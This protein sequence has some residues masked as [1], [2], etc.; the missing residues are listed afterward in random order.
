MKLIVIIIVIGL[1]GFFGWLFFSSASDDQIPSKP[2][3]VKRSLKIVAAG[4]IS[5]SDL[6]VTNT[7]CQQQ[8]TADLIQKINPDLVLALGDIQYGVTGIESY[9]NYYDKS[10]GVFKDK[11]RPAVGNHEYEEASATGYYDYFKAAAGDKGKG[12]YSFESDGWKF[13]ALNSNCWAVGGCDTD[14]P[15][16][17]WLENELKTGTQNCQ[18]VYF[19]HPLYSSGLHGMN[20]M[21]RPLWNILDEYKVELVLNGHD[22]MYERFALQDSKGM[23]NPSGVR[24]FVVGTGGRNLYQFKT[25]SPN[26]EKRI[27]DQFGVLE[28]E[29]KSDQYSWKFISVDNQILDQGSE[30]CRFNQASM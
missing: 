25:I 8:K 3:P 30:G 17:Q 13:I 11:T 21:T 4:D 27:N 2:L 28:L 26:S 24:E 15:Q 6:P 1:T 18:L 16:G 19:H 22:H 10:W 14:S 7:Q 23:A 29:L 20:E 5:C 12:Y 9:L